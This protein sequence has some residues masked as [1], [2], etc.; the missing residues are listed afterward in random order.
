MKVIF[1]D[2]DGVITSHNTHWT[3]SPVKMNYIA[4][5]CA[6]T[7]AKIVISSGWRMKDLET[8][9]KC[10]T[11]PNTPLVDGNPYTLSNLT[12]D[13]TPYFDHNK[14]GRGDEI[15]CW[16]GFHPEVTNYVI[17]D[18]DTFDMLPCQ[19]GHI[20]ES[21]WEDGISKEMVDEAIK[22]LNS[23]D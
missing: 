17:I 22:I 15:Q 8:T 19:E 3:L 23:K 10:I 9:L 11:N 5:I 21:D 6:E 4:R 16:L 13:V 12:I 7:G 18:D 1:L 20:I 2:F 14:Y